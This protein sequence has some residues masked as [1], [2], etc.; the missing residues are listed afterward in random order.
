MSKAGYPVWWD[1]TI[2]IFNK[3]ENSQTQ[4]VTWYKAVVH[5]CFWKYTG[6]KISIGQTVLETN[7][8]ICRIPKD[9]RFLEKHEWVAK[10]NDSMA[11]FFT[12]A[13]GDII[14]KGEVSDEI[15]E[16]QSGR[17]STDLIQKYKSLQGCMEIEE[18]AVNVGPGR[19]NEHYYVKGI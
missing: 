1:T 4:L 10:P 16:Y 6:D 17:R 15:D 8:T 11:D 12:L 14:V 13:P 2:T 7:N 19:C 3:Y 5:D 9:D 18:T